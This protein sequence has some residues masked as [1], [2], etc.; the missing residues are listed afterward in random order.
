MIQVQ[1][2]RLH[3]N[4]LGQ[5]GVAYPRYDGMREE[6]ISIFEQFRQFVATNDL[7]DVR[8]DQWEITY[9]NHIP[10]GTVW[11]TPADWNFFRPMVGVPT[12]SN[13]IEAESFGGEWHFVIPPQRGRLHIDWQHAR[14]PREEDETSEQDLIRLTLTARG[15]LAESADVTK[16][17][18]DGLDLGRTTIV[19]SGS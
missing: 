7:G 1:H 10:R 17:L 14:A 15:G 12:I 16:S 18:V 19:R 2:S 8:A 13:V 6:F 4:W 11:H 3:L 5:E 9:V